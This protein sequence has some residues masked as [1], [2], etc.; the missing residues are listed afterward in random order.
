M[1]VNP[2]LLYYD[3]IKSTIIRELML[4]SKSL[5]VTHIEVIIQV[6]IDGNSSKG[7]LC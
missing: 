5:S 6:F 4:S 7:Q 2:S 3:F 1:A